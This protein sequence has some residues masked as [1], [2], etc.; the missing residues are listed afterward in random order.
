MLAFSS[1]A[2]EL[3]RQLRSKNHSII[4]DT[5]LSIG[6]PTVSIVGPCPMLRTE[7]FSSSPKFNKKNTLRAG[8]VEGTGCPATCLD[9]AGNR[10]RD[11]ATELDQV[12]TEG[13]ITQLRWWN[14]LRS[15]TV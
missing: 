6:T 9:E 4:K 14:K 10:E 8:N 5:I 1:A 2:N 7:H 11:R 15:H 12:S 13:E 3:L